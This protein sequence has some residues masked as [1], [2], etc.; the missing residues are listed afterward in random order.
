MERLAYTT[1]IAADDAGMISATAWRYDRP[2]RTG[3]VISKGAFGALSLPMPM[4]VHHDLRSP[5]GS[6]SEA[7]ET[8]NALN[9]KGRLLTGKVGLADE[10]HALVVSGGIGAVSI[11]FLARK[12][13]PIK[14]GGRRIVEA[15]LLE[16]S[17]VT[18]G[19]HPDALVT[20]AK[21]FLGA[22]RLAQIINRAAAH[23]IRH[24]K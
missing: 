4:L 19:A 17:L 20:S 1:K 12:T 8:D 14:G 7:A 22:A 13:E 23:H 11:G 9:L 6:W 10:T 21:S 3:D 15:E 5:V 2:D 24:A 16:V 18:I